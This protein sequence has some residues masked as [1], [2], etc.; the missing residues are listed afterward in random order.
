MLNKHLVLYFCETSLE[1]YILKLKKKTF[2]IFLLYQCRL[3]KEV[4][5][6][7]YGYIY[8]KFVQNIISSVMVC[9][10]FILGCIK[11]NGSNQEP[12][13]WLHPQNRNMMGNLKK[14]RLFSILFRLLVRRLLTLSMGSSCQVDLHYRISS[15]VRLFHFAFRLSSV[16]RGLK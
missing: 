15:L 10:N 3:I 11:F 1:F 5:K 7:M 14:K 2:K 4:V 8:F 13:G 12:I 6:V 9:S 16:V